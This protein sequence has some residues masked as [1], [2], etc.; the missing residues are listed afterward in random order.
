MAD[1][2]EVLFR[3]VSCDGQLMRTPAAAMVGSAELGEALLATPLRRP[4]PDEAGPLGRPAGFHPVTVGG[5]RLEIAVT[6][7]RPWRAVK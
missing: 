7:W 6:H 2:A 3:N 1:P 4:G 5:W